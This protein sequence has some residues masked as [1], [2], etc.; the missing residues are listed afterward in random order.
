MTRFERL[1]LT[2]RVFCIAA[3]LG[4]SLAVFDTEAIRSTLLLAA[5]A[6]TAVAADLRSPFSRTSVG[7]VE[8][9]VVALIVGVAMPE[10][11]VLLPYLVIPSLVVGLAAGARSVLGVVGTET[12]AL[13]LVVLTAGTTAAFA[14]LAS[15]LL[16]WLITS[17]GVGLLC[18]W[19]REAGIGTRGIPGDA[20]YESA[21]RLL[22]QLRTVARRL[23]SGLDSVSMG[24]QL[25]VSVHQHIQDTH[26]A[27]FVRT[28]GG[29]LAPLGYRGPAA[30]EVLLPEVQ[31][32]E[33]C[34][35]EM[36]PVQEIR[37]SGVAERRNRVVLPL[38]AGERMIGVVLA[39]TPVPVPA[40][41]LQDLM[42]EL[43]EHAFRIDTALAFDEVRSLATME[44]RHRLAREIHD[45]VAQEIASL[46]YAVDDLS[47]TATT[48]LQRRKLNVLRSEITRVVSEL[49][50]SIFDLRSEVSGGLGSALSDYV[51]EMGARSGMTVHLTL[52]QAPT[53]LR[54]EVETELLRIAQEAITNARKHSAAKNLWV[55]CRIRPPYA[56]IKVSDDGLGLGEA[57]Q[58]S[59]GLGVMRERAE[60][61]SAR[62]DVSDNPHPMSGSGTVVTVTV[63]AE[64]PSTVEAG[65]EV[66]Q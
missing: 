61:I 36:N 40:K 3:I 23:S 52:D 41:V 38:R 29:V 47:A 6:A 48:D 15:T 26:S 45:G 44:E 7:I 11:L 32:V 22:T 50:L 55:D 58:D 25:L 28:D 10:G 20:S 18:A 4:L 9:A 54:S 65:S 34:W 33:T 49:R 39:D 16:P 35:T 62:L 24:S 14:P 46:G 21:R 37:A 56:R 30:K 2:S 27:I 8:S 13:S 63:G 53:R 42:Q 51:R 19:L 57:R 64:V 5:V 60:R 17:L 12:V 43:D 59:Y 1:N 31:E 66:R